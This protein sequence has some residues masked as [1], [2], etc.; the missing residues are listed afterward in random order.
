MKRRLYLE[1]LLDRRVV[2]R[3]GHQLGRIH[4]VIAEKHGNRYRVSQYRLGSGALIDRFRLTQWMFGRKPRPIVVP[5][6]EL[7]ITHGSAPC[8]VNTHGKASD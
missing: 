3:S 7:V 2:D 1:E 5:A 4:E 8:I 6:E